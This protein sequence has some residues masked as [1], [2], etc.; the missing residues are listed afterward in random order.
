M[1]QKF[2]PLWDFGNIKKL[3]DFLIKCYKYIED[4]FKGCHIISMPENM[5]GLQNHKWGHSPLHYTNIYYEYAYKAIKIISQ[6]HDNEELLLENL[7]MQYSIIGKNEEIDAKYNKECTYLKNQLTNA[8]AVLTKILADRK[9]NS[10]V[11][12]LLKNETDVYQYLRKL[13]LVKNNY[14]IILTVK[15][16]AGNTWTDEIENELRNG[17]GFSKISKNY[18]LMYIGICMNGK[19][20][21]DIAAEKS[22]QA[23][24]LNEQYEDI[25][26]HLESRPFK[27]GNVSITEINGKNYSTNVRGVNITVYDPIKKEAVDSVGFDHQDHPRKLVRLS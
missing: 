3:H 11:E 1:Y 12:I 16:T 15:G 18:G 24:V 9:E 10:A 7:R 22:G 4:K 17:L 6:S 20:S 14:C 13:A 5:H 26:L 21:A 8:T 2:G 27:D 19:I 25:T 23:L